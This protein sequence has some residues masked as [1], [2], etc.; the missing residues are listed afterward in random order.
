MR[1]PRPATVIT[2]IAAAAIGGGFAKL[3]LDDAVVEVALPEPAPPRETPGEAR[4]EKADAAPPAF[5][6]ALSRAE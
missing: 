3:A 6:A 4:S 1:K 2:W 5:G